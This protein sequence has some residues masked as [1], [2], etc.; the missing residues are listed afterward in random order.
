VTPCFSIKALSFEN[1]PKL[2]LYTEHWPP[3]Q[4][5][6][7]QGQL[8]GISVDKVKNTLESV[9]WPYE[10]KVLPWARAIKEVNSNGNSLIFSTARFAERENKFQWLA[11]LASVKSKLITASTHATI[12]INTIADV[13]DYTLILKRG[14][15]STTFFIENNLI[16]EDKV[17]WVNNSEQA[18]NLLIKGR[19]DLYPVTTDSFI[20]AVKDS[21]Y[22]LSQFNYVFDFKQLDVDLFLATSMNENSTLV[23]D[24]QKL[25][26][27]NFVQ[28]K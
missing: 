5:V 13:K 28:I 19:G 4:L 22:Q 10:I 7:Q 21:S 11:R 23:N 8:S 14:E 9:Q 26:K 24:L 3:Y 2:T 18:L 20:S 6:D 12:A 17:I 25:F 27:A 1:K 15:A 16:D